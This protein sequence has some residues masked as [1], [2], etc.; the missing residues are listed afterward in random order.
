MTTAS[1][2]PAP[3]PAQ[4]VRCTRCA[5]I[6]PVSRRYCN[7]C[8]DHLLQPCPHC[9]VECAV[10]ENYCGQCGGDVGGWIAEQRHRIEQTCQ[11]AL[12]YRASD[13]L[14]QSLQVL[15]TVMRQDHPALQA[16]SQQASLLYEQIRD[17]YEQ[18]RDEV[19][20]LVERA[21]EQQQA[22]QYAVAYALL[23]RIPV[24]LRDKS[25]DCRLA[26]LR[27][28]ID[29]LNEL[30]GEIRLAITSQQTDDMLPQVL[31]LLKEQPHDQSVFRLAK[32]LLEQKRQLA[33][34]ALTARRFDEA[35]ELFCS[36]P[37]PVRSEDV[38]K[39]LH[40]LR[41]HAYRMDMIRSAP[42][43]DRTL[44][45]VAK[46]LLKIVEPKEPIAKLLLQVAHRRTKAAKA[47]RVRPLWARTPDEG[48]FGVPIVLINDPFGIN[49]IAACENEAYRK[50]PERFHVAI[51]VA[52]QGLDGGGIRTNLAPSKQTG[53]KSKIGRIVR[54]KKADVKTSWGIDFDARELRVVRLERD[55]EE[56]VRICHAQNVPV[57]DSNDAPHADRANDPGCHP[58]MAKAIQSVCEE[59][60]LAGQQIFLAIPGIQVLFRLIDIP[61]STKNKI[62]SAIRFEA[63]YQIPF[64]LDETNWDY[65]VLQGIDE[66]ASSSLTV[67]V[68]L[69]AV[70]QRYVAERLKVFQEAGVD[71]NAV[72]SSTAALYN[73][74]LR[75][76]AQVER[77]S[78][79]DGKA[80]AL[81]DVGY[82]SSSFIVVG[83]GVFWSRSWYRGVTSCEAAVRASL[84]LDSPSAVRALQEPSILPRLSDLAS[85][86]SPFY[87]TMGRE[88]AMCLSAFKEIHPAVAIE[89]IVG[90]GCGIQI[91]GLISFLRRGNVPIL[92]RVDT[93]SS[94]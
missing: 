92:D 78:N 13:E 44:E 77:L 39:K 80:I 49:D 45:Q 36:I 15:S 38:V 14:E 61:G 53:I 16:A 4:H 94:T 63:K 17:F 68:A 85:A 91:H 51:G 10:D 59:L 71:L 43:A 69:L 82:D 32:K 55:E 81:L 73:L 88:L 21:T 93:K 66:Q 20:S 57:T 67:P 3:R 23:E 31:T 70:K 58:G 47:N 37:S 30:R 52:L 65:H 46:G 79:A 19:A 62:E 56:G 29:E 50:C 64:S 5:E 2:Q 41:E 84:G 33:N 54:P 28:K 90:T 40:R 11:S 75:H 83:D 25:T 89:R 24:P 35:F 60:D 12:V 76:R 86:L 9:G 22:K 74:A 34:H 6:N 48:H 26:A 7:Q 18:R 87:E 8:G 42:V 27:Q 72:Q 1:S